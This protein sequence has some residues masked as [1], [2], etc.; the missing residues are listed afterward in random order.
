MT[1]LFDDLVWRGLVHDV[2]DTGLGELLSDEPITL[3]HGIEPTADS[4]AVHHL[5][6]I[7]GMMRMQ[8]AG[9]R[10]IAVIGGATALIGDPSG[11]AG[12]RALLSVEEVKAF[13]EGIRAQLEGFLDFSAG[14]AVLYDNS[15]WLQPM[16]LMEFLRD[17]GKHFTVNTMIAKESVRVR[18]QEREQGISFTEFSYMLLQAY[19]FLYLFDNHD[20][21]LQIGGSDQWGNITMG[22]DL[23]RRVRGV[24]VH[25]LTWPLITDAAGT[26]MGKSA[27]NS[28]WLDARRTSPYQLY[29]F[30]VRTEDALVGR[31]LRAFTFL[32]RERIEELDEETGARPEKREAQHALARE[33]TTLV[34][35]PTAAEQ[36][37][38]AADV[39]FTEEIAALDEATL[40]DLFSDAPS[41]TRSRGDL[42]QGLS[43]VDAL[44]GTVV[45]SKSAARTT[46]S[47]GGAYVNNRRITDVDAS[48]TRADTIADRYV[49]L[50]R[51]RREHHLL[52]FE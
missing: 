3:Y 12:E 47:Q 33:V 22:V 42:D 48:I 24:G 15:E 1:A 46:I 19:D 35:G 25:A 43:L 50:R 34:H 52:R 36:A 45:P 18:L 39:L 27:G 44:T 51:G 30:F 23:V 26:K 10:P 5:L 8:Q 28:V 20:C 11:A 31:Y 4:L 13:V 7:L 41:S 6:G 32:E 49:V 17:T 9:H 40:L 2:T 37:R 29:Q 38:R 21:R 14:G 16:P